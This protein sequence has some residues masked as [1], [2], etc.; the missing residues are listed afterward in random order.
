MY[1]L[2]VAKFSPWHWHNS[3]THTVFINFYQ[4]MFIYLSC[5]KILCIMNV[6][7]NFVL[8]FILINNNSQKW[9]KK[10][11][12]INRLH[13]CSGLVFQL[14]HVCI[15]A[16]SNHYSIDKSSCASIFVNMIEIA[17]WRQI[18]WNRN[19]NNNLKFFE[20]NIRE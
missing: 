9:F 10:M 4:S 13:L 11:S 5:L 16:S 3:P 17:W 2:W 15:I 14:L 6:R 19:Q 12:L 8:I 7:F 1:S 18:R 20:I